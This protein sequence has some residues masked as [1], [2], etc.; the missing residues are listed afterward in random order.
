M[1]VLNDFKTYSWATND[2]LA[3]SALRKA[4]G[5]VATILGD[6]EEAEATET[7]DGNG[8]YTLVLK[9]TPVVS[10]AELR[11]SGDLVDT[12]EYFPN[13][14]GIRMYEKFPRG[15]GVI[16]VKYTAWWTESTI[17]KRLKYAIYDL[18]WAYYEAWDSLGNSNIKRESIDGASIEWGDLPI[19][20]P[21]KVINSYK[22]IH[23]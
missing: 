6:I 4:E 13:E 12:T 3:T 5:F 14:F 18:A 21:L 9:R 11:F 10:V 22:A 8:E 19:S 2:T 15:F 23:V 20:E 16:T 7:Y 17:P 1:L